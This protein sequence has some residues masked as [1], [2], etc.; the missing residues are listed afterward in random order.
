MGLVVGAFVGAEVGFGV[1]EVVGVGVGF[2]VGAGVTGAGVGFG[3]GL[4]V[5]E[6][7]SPGGQTESSNV[8]VNVILWLTSPNS[9]EMPVQVS[10][11]YA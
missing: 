1:G 2:G 3:V 11:P 9:I 7:V 4:V 6:G 10:Y 8:T 5:V